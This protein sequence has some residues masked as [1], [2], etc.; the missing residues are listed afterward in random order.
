MF[1]DPQTLYI[2]LLF[3]GTLVGFGAFF[4]KAAWWLR[5]EFQ[6]VIHMVQT[7]MVAQ[8]QINQRRHE[9]NIERFTK[10]ETKLD[11]VLK[12]GH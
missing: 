8:E 11:I 1:T 10:L 4:W 6:D 7:W 9:N 2:A 5:D 3:V 12:N